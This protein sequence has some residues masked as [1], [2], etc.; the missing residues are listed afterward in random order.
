MLSLS[1]GL[2]QNNDKMLFEADCCF[3]PLSTVSSNSHET[4]VKLLAEASVREKNLLRELERMQLENKELKSAKASLRAENCSEEEVE[5]YTGLPS[6]SCF[7]WLVLFMKDDIPNSFLLNNDDIV[8]MTFMKLRLNLTHR[9]LGFRFGVSL[10]TV[11]NYIETM[12]PK[13]AE[14]LRFFIRWP[15][16]DDV[17]RSRPQCFKETYPK[18]V[19]IIDCTEVFIQCPGNFSA[20]AATYSNYKSTNTVKYLVSITPAGSVSFVSKAFGGK[21]SD[22]VITIESGFLNLLHHG[23]QV[24]ADR[25]FLIREELASCGAELI[26]PAFTKGKP[27]LS[28]YEVENSRKISNVRIHVE[29][30]M[31]RLKNFRVLS[32]RMPMNMVPHADSIMTICAAIVNLHPC[33]VN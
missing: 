6:M 19:S 1:S 12:I 21:A 26:M 9:D 5:F 23:D 32:E 22:K 30:A 24:M 31:E 27:Q 4:C 15:E 3:F 8:L 33:L 17:L 20:R 14:K 28:A 16:R 2:P 11:T 10:P 29:R 13:L 25:G 18:C 7:Q